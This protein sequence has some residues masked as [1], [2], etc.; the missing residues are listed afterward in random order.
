MLIAIGLSADCF[1]VAVSSSLARKSVSWPGLL[2]ISLSFGLFQAVMPALGWLAGRT[3]VDLIASYDHWVAFI[4][5][6]AVGG[7]M[8][9]QSFHES[10]DS[11]RDVDVTR[12][13][14]L[15]TMSVATSIDSLAVGLSFAFLQVKILL[16]S[17]TIG[18]V[19]ALITAAGFLLGAKIGKFL[20][21][22]V[23][24]IG[25]LIL[26]AIGLR[27]LITHLF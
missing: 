27:I 21:K 23:E 5:L 15:L 11:R 1:V 22:R 14:L 8:G 25:G 13:L 2:R 19:A 6:L 18:V 10:A 9:W 17:L 3:I 7:R 20:E 16:A 26:I 24:A 12:G 4:L